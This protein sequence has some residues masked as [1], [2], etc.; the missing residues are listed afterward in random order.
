MDPGDLGESQTYILESV[1]T[2]TQNPTGGSTSTTE[3]RVVRDG[4][5][6]E[7]QT[8]GLTTSGSGLRPR[9]RSSRIQ[10]VDAAQEVIT[11]KVTLGAVLTPFSFNLFILKVGDEIR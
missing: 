8:E 6:E 10:E 7:P 11:H 5:L 2:R 1:H 9:R 4:H 3:Y